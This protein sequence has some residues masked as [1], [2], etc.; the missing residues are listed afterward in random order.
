MVETFD[1]TV[2]ARVAS[3]CREFVEIY[4]FINSC[5]KLGAEMESVVRVEGEW[6]YPERDERIFK[7][8][9]STFSCKFRGGDIEHV[10]ATT[11]AVREWEDG[12]ISSGR[13]R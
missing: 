8:V 13:G 5:S 9:G 3:A 6:A 7:H 2:S 4:N 12:G 11:G 10:G 1:A